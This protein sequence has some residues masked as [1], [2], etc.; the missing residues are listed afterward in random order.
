MQQETEATPQESR[1]HSA[2][3]G[4]LNASSPNTSLPRYHVSCCLVLDGM[5]GLDGSLTA[6]CRRAVDVPDSVRACFC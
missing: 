1:P 3:L 4:P 6:A 2:S 5:D